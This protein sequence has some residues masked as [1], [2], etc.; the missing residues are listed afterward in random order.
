MEAAMTDEEEESSDERTQELQR[1]ISLLKHELVKWKR[2]DD[3][4]KEAMVPLNKYRKTINELRE[5]WDEEL[6][7]QKFQWDGVKKE[8][9]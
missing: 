8:L 2:H 4:W 6:I 3:Q 9:K 7:F 5:K 1:E